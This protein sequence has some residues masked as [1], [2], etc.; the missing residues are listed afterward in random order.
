MF[1]V[2]MKLVL[3]LFLHFKKVFSRCYK[4]IFQDKISPTPNTALLQ[5]FY[6]VSIECLRVFSKVSPLWRSEFKQ[7]PDL[8]EHQQQFSSAAQLF[9][10]FQQQFFVKLRR[11][12]VCVCA[13]QFSRSVVQFSCSVVSDSLRPH[14]LQHT[15]PPC[16]SPT[17]RVHPDSRPS[18]Q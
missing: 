3:K 6:E 14:E 10:F 18:S 4:I 17:P 2:S 5:Y 15:R 16:L 13:H 9:S 11:F 7:L 8:G 1:M 12:C